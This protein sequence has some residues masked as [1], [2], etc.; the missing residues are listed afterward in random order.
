MKNA[1]FYVS[2]IEEAA[3]HLRDKKYGMVRVLKLYHFDC[4][5]TC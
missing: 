3:T 4:I 1:R 5:L 2:T